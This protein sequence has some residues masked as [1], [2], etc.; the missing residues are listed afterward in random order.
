MPHKS[1]HPKK[2]KK[3]DRVVTILVDVTLKVVVDFTTRP[4]TNPN[5]VRAWFSSAE[6]DTLVAINGLISSYPGTVTLVST[7][8]SEDITDLD[9]EPGGEREWSV[10]PART[11]VVDVD[12]ETSFLLHMDEYYNLV[13]TEIETRLAAQNVLHRITLI[14]WHLHF[15][16]GPLDVVV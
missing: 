5:T 12:D 11:A 15:S 4:Q 6:P 1:K 7:Q 3:K 16:T 2:P 8:Y 13:R 14:A 9:L 10:Y